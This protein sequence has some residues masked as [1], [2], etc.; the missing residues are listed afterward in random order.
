MSSPTG[1]PAHE[2]EI[3]ERPQKLR[4]YAAASGINHQ[5]QEARGEPSRKGQKARHRRML[6]HGKPAGKKNSAA[7][8]SQLLKGE[9]SK[10]GACTGRSRRLQPM[11]L[12]GYAMGKSMPKPGE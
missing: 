2:P 12:E 8:R 11:S 4:L 5:D 10:G 1:S 9:V 6:G 3:S 7:G